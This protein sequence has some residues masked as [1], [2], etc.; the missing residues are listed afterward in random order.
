[1]CVAPVNEQASAIAAV[2]KPIDTT[3][4]AVLSDPAAFNNKM[5]RIRAYYW[6]NEENYT[7]KDRRCDGALWF[8]YAGGAL[9][10]LGSEDPEGKQVLPVPVSLARDFKLERF[11]K[12]V[13]LNPEQMVPLI[14]EPAQHVTA[15]FVGRIDSVSSE[16]HEFLKQHA[17][18]HW[19]LGFGHL[20]GYEAELILQYVADDATVE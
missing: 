15:T 9:N 17:T 5:V 13:R 7:L 11:E 6:G 4:C 1:M 14:G 20:G 18:E 8:W 19:G 3:V 10:G 12:L 2:R 16:V